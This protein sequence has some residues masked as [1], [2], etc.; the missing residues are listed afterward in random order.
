VVLAGRFP[1]INTALKPMFSLPSNAALPVRAERCKM[2]SNSV[3]SSRRAEMTAPTAS[4]AIA[5]AQRSQSIPD[6]LAQKDDG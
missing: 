4:G 5:N 3:T 2:D 6:I 1:S